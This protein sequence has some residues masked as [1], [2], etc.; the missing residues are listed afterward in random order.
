[1]A[2]SMAIIANKGY[3]Y[4]PHFVKS[5]ENETEKDTVMRKYRQ[6][7]EVLTHISDDVY[8]IVQE[9]MQDVVDHGTARV[10][11][12]PG[13]NICAKTGTAEN[14]T[15]L[16]GKVIQLKDNSMFV[17]FAPREDP[18]I[19]VAVVVQNA[20]YG[21]TWAAPI[22][23]LMVEK[24]LTDSLRTERQAEVKRISEANI[25]PD[26]FERLQFKTDSIRAYK[27]FNLTKDSNYIKKY[28]PR[29]GTKKVPHVPA[30]VTKTVKKEQMINKNL[31]AKRT[32]TDKRNP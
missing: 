5:I 2:N 13:I 17:C 30:P 15:V 3:Y 16:D 7:H 25:I 22:G 6:K 10:A 20:G 12:I 28:L 27:W 1:M 9:G 23:S 14:K 21:A 29:H 31:Y 4:I 8:D 18:K 26:Y 19:C 24:Y 32:T 11:Q